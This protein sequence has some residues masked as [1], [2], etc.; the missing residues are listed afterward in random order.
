MREEDGRA[1]PAH[2]THETRTERRER[3]KTECGGELALGEIK[4][5]IDGGITSKGGGLFRERPFLTLRFLTPSLPPLFV[6][7]HWCD[8][9]TK[10]RMCRPQETLPQRNYFS[11]CF[12]CDSSAP[13]LDIA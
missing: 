12:E 13:C 8:E 1:T 6:L 10:L 2:Y 4:R 9:D 7:Y 5:L 3:E 11:R